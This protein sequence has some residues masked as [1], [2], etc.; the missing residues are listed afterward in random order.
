M[1]FDTPAGRGAASAPRAQHRD[2]G[3]A[4]GRIPSKNARRRPLHAVKDPGEDAGLACRR[5]ARTV[6]HKTPAAA[7]PRYAAAMTTNARP[8]HVR[9]NLS[10]K[11]SRA[12]LHIFICQHMRRGA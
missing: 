3:D 4:Q 7:P 9:F 6:P 2:P 5:N 8:I 11:T 10:F 1:R 12:R